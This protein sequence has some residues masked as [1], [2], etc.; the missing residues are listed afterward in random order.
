MPGS[1]LTWQHWQPPSCKQELRK[2]SEQLRLG[3]APACNH[4]LLLM[5]CPLEARQ[6]AV[7]LWNTGEDAYRPDA[8][9]RFI[10]IQR[11]AG[12]GSGYQLSGERG[13]I[14]S[15]SRDEMLEVIDHL[16]IDAANPIAGVCRFSHCDSLCCA[17]SRAPRA[18][19]F[20]L[21]VLVR[22]LA[23][24]RRSAQQNIVRLNRVLLCCKHDA[25]SRGI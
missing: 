25:E 20:D 12:S 5:R 7:T 1:C 19:P 24:A 11:R 4:P 14:V 21:V 3:Y 16:S 23:S 18:P 15:R 9:G 13:N 17:V 22:A 2:A 10:T 8:Y 6:V